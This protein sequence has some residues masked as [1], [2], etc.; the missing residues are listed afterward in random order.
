MEALTEKEREFKWKTSL[1]PL[2]A[3]RESGTSHTGKKLKIKK[4]I[5][6]GFKEK[7]NRLIK[8]NFI[9]API[10]PYL[11]NGFVPTRVATTSIK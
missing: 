5:W 6:R 10:P 3:A 9:S 1:L 8:F 7:V 11:Q 4:I 2:G